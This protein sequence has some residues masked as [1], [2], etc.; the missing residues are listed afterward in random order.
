MAEN[1]TICREKIDYNY[2]QFDEFFNHELTKC[3]I[4]KSSDYLRKALDDNYV[5]S[6]K[7][8]DNS[9]LFRESIVLQ[10]EFLHQ[11]VTGN[12]GIDLEPLCILKH[13]RSLGKIRYANAVM[14]LGEAKI[15]PDRFEI[16]LLSIEGELL[17]KVTIL[18]NTS[19]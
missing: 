4:I 10:N 16:T 2:C 6:K 12:G 8:F 3:G 7:I 11:F 18:R 14:G 9:Q 1:E 19:D 13:G 17:Y 15:T 5:E